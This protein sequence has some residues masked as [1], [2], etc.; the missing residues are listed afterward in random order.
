MR[1]GARTPSATPGSGKQREPGASQRS[2]GHAP[3]RTGAW[4]PGSRYGEPEGGGVSR[5]K[6]VCP[7]APRGR[8]PASDWRPQ[9]LRREQPD[10]GGLQSP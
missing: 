3:S 10:N 8:A 4:R 7:R 9:R 2:A 1:S 5:R 6:G